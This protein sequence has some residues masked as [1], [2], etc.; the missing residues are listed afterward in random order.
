MIFPKTKSSKKKHSNDLGQPH[1]VSSI[2]T[3]GILLLFFVLLVFLAAR[4]WI[5]DQVNS[6]SLAVSHTQE[7]QKELRQVFSALQDAE[8]GQRGY[9]LTTD[10]SYLVPYQNARWTIFDAIAR[11]QNLTSDDAL[12]QR[13]IK[14]LSL[15]A[16]DKLSELGETIQLHRRGEK[17]EALAIVTSDKGKLLMDAFRDV[18]SSM[19]SSE[20]SVLEVKQLV[21]FQR[22]RAARWID[23]I[24]FI[25]FFVVVSI[26]V[27][28]IGRALRFRQIAESTLIETQAYNRLILDSAGQ[29]IY[30]L[31][32]NG[33]ITFV[34][35]K[36]CE[37]LGYSADELLGQHMH[38]L[39]Q[40]EIP[41]GSSDPQTA[42]AIS[43]DTSEKI[44]GEILT[45]KD[46]TTFPSDY[47]STSTYKNG[48]KTGTVVV[49]S[50]ITERKNLEE[51][52][53][54]SQKLESLGQL[55]GGIAHDFN[56]LLGVML[57]NAEM[58]EAKL[59]S[60]GDPLE[61]T[62]GIVKA[63]EKA[64]SLTQRLLAFSRQQPLAPVTSSISVIIHSM[65]DM[66]T[67]TLGATIDLRIDYLDRDTN[68]L[69]DKNQLENAVLNIALNAR[70]AM[71]SGGL[72]RIQIKQKNLDE[73]YVR[74]YEDLKAGE[75]IEIEF[76]DTGFGMKPDIARKVFEPFYTTKEV[77]A[78]SGLGL[79]MVY[80]FVKQS[81]GHITIVSEPDVGT[82]V[83]LYLPRSSETTET[84]LIV[85][86]PIH[87]TQGTGRIL[88][89][90]DEPNLRHISVGALSSAGY[91]VIEAEDGVTALHKLRN[92]PRVDLLFTDLV[93]PGGMTGQDIAQR[94]REIQNN[95]KVLYTTGYAESTLFRNQELD[96]SISLLQKPFRRTD[97]L[98][99]VT[100]LLSVN[101]SDTSPSGIDGN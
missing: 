44:T 57:G 34:N 48:E 72:L 101:E 20:T 73:D 3:R 94:A 79:S 4:V 49:V 35:R 89:V 5:S 2:G 60:G 30:G 11:L 46:G 50:D 83:R 53:R 74:N 91:D 90:E 61:F 80:G 10:S 12:Q 81:G 14:E 22:K 86:T 28:Q 26:V 32:L 25:I 82:T 13:N 36:V 1:S 85:D 40:C 54:R 100:S 55:S 58:V 98:T 47:V 39:A 43:N 27:I 38:T 87:L 93:L 96:P 59:E 51:R 15:L 63:I 66:L 19:D 69:V 21:H 99:S 42:P 24:G 71:P 29:G 97:L 95:I 7:V 70:D 23:F 76:G 17:K 8:T 9:L 84:P 65:E 33:N 78:G 92:G 77:G 64:A 16:A 67:R 62:D 75:Y 45:R 37:L 41:D 56:N 68:A 52:L 18:I 31:D 6:A 88:V